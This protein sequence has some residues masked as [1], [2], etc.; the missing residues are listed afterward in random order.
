M[1]RCNQILKYQKIFGALL[2]S[3]SFKGVSVLNKNLK[4]I[5]DCRK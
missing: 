3:K 2:I 1:A 4:E 5:Y